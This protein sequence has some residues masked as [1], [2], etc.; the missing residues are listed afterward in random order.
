MATHNNWLTS[1]ID[2]RLQLKTVDLHVRLIPYP[3]RQMPFHKAADFTARLIAENHEKIFVALSGG[4]DSDFVTRCFHRCGIEFTP[5][6]VKTSGNAKELSY[7]FATCEELNI[8]PVVIDLPDDKYLEF[9]FENVVKRIHGYGIYAVPSIIACEHA[10]NNGGVLIIGEHM[11]DTDKH[12]GNIVPGVNEWDFYNECFIGEDYSIPFF[13]YTIE[14][15]YA[16]L[17]AIEAGIAIDKFKAKL[18]NVKH[19]P[20]MEYEFSEKFM[21]IHQQ[22]S[23]RRKKAANPSFP[24]ETREKLI[25]FLDLWKKPNV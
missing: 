4:A 20:I 8:K 17:I 25:M 16:M 11:L 15:T 22:A 1:N 2:E 12:N 13:L 23:M 7:A 21:A 3:F 14:L 10:R 18:Y 19:R 5:I 6:I 9:Y 24:L